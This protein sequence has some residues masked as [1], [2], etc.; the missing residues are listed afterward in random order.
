[1]YNYF[2][3]EWCLNNLIWVFGW[4]GQNIDCVY[5]FGC[6][7][8]DVVGVDIYVDDYGNQV[9]LFVQ[10]KWIVGDSVLICLYENGL[11]LDLVMLGLKVDW[12]WFMIWYFCWLQDFRQNVFVLLCDYY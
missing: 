3:V 2:V 6:D 1:M 7:C 4:V 11:I 8:V 12:V 9:G 5:Y 10:V